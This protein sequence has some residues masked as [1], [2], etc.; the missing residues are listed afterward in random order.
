MAT[1]DVA[2]QTTESFFYT[3]EHMNKLMLRHEPPDQ[4]NLWDRPLYRVV[5]RSTLSNEIL[6]ELRI[7]QEYDDDNEKGG[8]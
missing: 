6:H 3:E 8:G 5:V 4:R 7:K 1:N 2:N